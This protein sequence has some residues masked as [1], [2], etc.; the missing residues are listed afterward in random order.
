MWRWRDRHR[1]G[2]AT[3]P[4][5]CR[6][7]STRGCERSSTSPS[8]RSRSR[9]SSSSRRD[10]PPACTCSRA[11][12]VSVTTRGQSNL[13]KGRIAVRTN[14]ANA[15]NDKTRHR[16]LDWRITG[17]VALWRHRCLFTCGDLRNSSFQTAFSRKCKYVSVST[18]AA[19]SSFYAS[20]VVYNTGGRGAARLRDC[21]G[22][23]GWDFL[24][25]TLVILSTRC[26]TLGDRAFPVTADRA[27]N[28][29][30]LYVRSAPSLLQF[31]RDLKTA[32]H[33]SVIVL[34]TIVSSCVTDCN[35]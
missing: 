8:R 24:L 17:A 10:R 23:H 1:A 7:C 16:Y 12:N 31:R 20:T 2:C 19:S 27:W 30:L 5:T 32:L 14:R 9:G 4:W 21:L 22:R 6:R 28:A 3:A 13:T 11:R 18:T 29:L 26:T 33:V 34:F 15:C 35:L 25:M